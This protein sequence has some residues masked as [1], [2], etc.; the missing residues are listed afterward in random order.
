MNLPQRECPNDFWRYGRALVLLATVMR[1][2]DQEYAL[3]VNFLS[4]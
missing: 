1:F 3:A 2:A 4:I